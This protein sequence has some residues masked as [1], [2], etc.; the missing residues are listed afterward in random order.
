MTKPVVK[1][2]PRPEYSA[3]LPTLEAEPAVSD[4]A[5]QAVVY[6]CWLAGA[7]RGGNGVC[8]HAGTLKDFYEEERD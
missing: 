8:W 4:D 3:L 1:W 5:G 6:R 2:K 7:G